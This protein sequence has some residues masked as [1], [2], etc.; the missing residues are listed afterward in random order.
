M[1]TVL[2]FLSVMLCS[3]YLFTS[4][5]HADFRFGDDVVIK[6]GETA[7]EAVCFGA[8]VRVYGTVSTTAFSLGGDVIVENG[9][10]VKGDAISFGG[11]VRVRGYGTVYKD[12][13]S[14]GGSVRVDD[15]ATVLGSCVEPL[16]ELEGKFDNFPG[17][18]FS[19]CSHSFK[20]FTDKIPGIFLFGPLIG[21]FGVFGF[22]LATVFLIVKLAIKLGIAALLVSIFPQHIDTMAECV[23]VNFLK[24]LLLGLLCIFAIPF[25]FILL[26]VSILGIPFLPLYIG[27]LILTYLFGSVGL[28]L[29][30]GRI[31]PAAE[32][33][34]V[35]RNTL[36]GVLFIGLIR[37]LPVLGL[38]IGIGVTAISFGVIVLS[39]FG[40][41]ITAGT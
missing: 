26:L 17:S 12:A 29:Y 10:A 7:E 18:F 16:E 14:I 4:S 19:E 6:A 31:L 40:T 28:S 22:I 37:F 34:S 2:I 13:V 8:N 32:H 25:A 21:L 36:L 5:V 39:R 23:R 1:R 38:L 41:S 15:D 3:M 11:D 9:G 27:F 24:S 35:M 20:N 33:R 30:A